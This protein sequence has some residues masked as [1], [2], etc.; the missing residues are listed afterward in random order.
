MIKLKTVIRKIKNHFDPSYR[1]KLIGELV[2]DISDP[3]PE[4]DMMP[5]PL[6]AQ[7]AVD[8]LFHY[9]R[10]PDAY[11]TSPVCAKQF[12]SEAIYEIMINNKGNRKFMKYLE[13][14][15]GPLQEHSKR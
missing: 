2:F 12:N 11:I 15:Y 13:E 3:W 1:C 14:K 9:F 6:D 8:T 10:G 4:D 7:K 5:P